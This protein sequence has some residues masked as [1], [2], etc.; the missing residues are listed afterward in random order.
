MPAI[1][2]TS[3]KFQLDPK[4]AY[5][6]DNTTGPLPDLQFEPFELGNELI[7]QLR[8]KRAELLK[9]IEVV[10]ISFGWREGMPP[11]LFL[12]GVLAGRMKDTPSLK[13]QVA[14][15]RDLDENMAS[16][17]WLAKQFGMH[18]KK[19]VQQRAIYAREL[20]AAFQEVDRLLP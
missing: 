15:S 2:G 19:S 6:S 7:G 10:K 16:I 18:D 13:G 9:F 20:A 5:F 8:A 12:E 4:V 14:L 17:E 3:P 1:I 11:Y